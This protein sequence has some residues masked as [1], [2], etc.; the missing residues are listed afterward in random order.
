[1]I[2]KVR[3]DGYISLLILLAIILRTCSNLKKAAAR[4]DCRSCF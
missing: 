4:Q 2:V 3:N 1:M